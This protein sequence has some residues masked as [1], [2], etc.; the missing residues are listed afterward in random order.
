ML[1]STQIP[2]GPNYCQT[3]SRATRAVASPKHP[4][5]L[6]QT[7]G[8]TVMPAVPPKAIRKQNLAGKSDGTIILEESPSPPRSAIFGRLAGIK[9][10]L[11]PDCQIGA[12]AS[13]APPDTQPELRSNH[14]NVCGFNRCPCSAPRTKRGCHSFVCQHSCPAMTPAPM[15][16][17]DP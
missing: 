5:L 17:P 14:L 3:V 10:A 16:A 9:S 4:N 1:L 2:R 8:S 7:N 15:A 12:Q 13:P 6:L 11:K